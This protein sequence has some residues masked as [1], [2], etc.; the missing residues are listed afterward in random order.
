[1]RESFVARYIPVLF[2]LAWFASEGHASF[3]TRKG[4]RALGMAGAFTGQSNS[5]DAVF[6]NPAGLWQLA[7]LSG[8]GFYSAPFNLRE[9]TTAS[10]VVALPI[11]SGSSAASVESF[12]F[13]LYRETSLAASYALA[14]R[15]RWA[16][17]VN[18]RYHHVTIRSAGSASTLGVDVGAL[19][20]PHTI[21]QFGFMARN[22]NKP[23][24]AGESL[25]QVLVFGT[26]LCPVDRLTVNVDVYKDWRFP[27]DVRAGMEFQLHRTLAVRMGIGREPSR[28]S[29]GMGID[30]TLGQLDYALDIHPELG[31]TH[32][33]S[34][35]F[36]LGRRSSRSLSAGPVEGQRD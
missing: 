30:F 26:S 32:A 19:I 23:S 1:M 33:V 14:F 21:V 24:I 2:L 12:G 28:V 36:T 3:D 34:A 20:K 13:D 4:A 27:T 35:S 15:Q 18:V 22:L 5:P 9:L 7:S 16:V 6:Y 10:F 31:I 8:Q 11:A 29:A 25:P 17:G